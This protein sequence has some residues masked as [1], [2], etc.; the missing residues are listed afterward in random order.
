MLVA[1]YPPNS[2][3]SE[4]LILDTSEEEVCIRFGGVKEEI[5]LFERWVTKRIVETAC[6]LIESIKND[7]AVAVQYFK[8][9]RCVAGRICNL[10]KIDGNDAPPAPY[11]AVV[12]SWSGEQ[13]FE[14]TEGQQTAGSDGDSA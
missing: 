9:G 3:I 11:R 10:A 4:P 8:D 13:D 5:G 7:E 6:L 14:M 1:I 2:H 12:R